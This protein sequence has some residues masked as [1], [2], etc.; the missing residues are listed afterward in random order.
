MYQFSRAIYREIA[1][2]I[3]EDPHAD[4]C[5]AN[6][7]RV[8]RACEAAIERLATDRHYFARP[9][10]TLFH[11]IRAYFPMS[12]QPRVLRVIERYLQMRRR[13]H[14]LPAAERLRRQRQSAAVPGEHAQG[15]AVPAH[16]AAP[17]RLL[18]LA[19]AP[20]RDR[21]AGRGGRS[22]LSALAA[23][24]RYRRAML[25]GVDVGGTFTDA[26]L[27]VDGRRGHRQVADHSRGPVRGRAGGDQ[28][29]AG[30]GRA[31]PAGDVAEF[32]HG[33]TV[34]TNALLE[35]HGARTAFVATRGLHR[36]RRPRPPEPARALSPVRRTAGAPHPRGRAG[37]APP[38]G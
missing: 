35:G 15:H 14:A 5:H 13:V 31:R 22:P 19:P 10:R 12:A 17:Q 26:V 34:A 29:R 20:R 8:L 6:H 37:S 7:E 30:E 4:N 18:P 9:A 1:A 38:S 27:A 28:R 2:E 11:D 33:M 23:R 21:G 32:A 36:H 3:I 25:L 24:T 16:A